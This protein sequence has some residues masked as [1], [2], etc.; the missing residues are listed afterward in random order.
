MTEFQSVAVVFSVSDISATIRWYEEQLGFEGDPFPSTEPYVFA[1][2]RRDNV[3]IMLQRIVGYEKPN[4]YDSRSGGVWDAYIRVEGV[5]EFFELVKDTVQV[6]QP[7][8]RQPYGNW[9]F[10]VRDPNGYLL[11]F[12]EPS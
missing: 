5:K 11:V 12:S 4:L 3:E 8:R 6:V 10:E 9:E 2:L 7:L 1:I